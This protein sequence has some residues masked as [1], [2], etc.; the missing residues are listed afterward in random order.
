M[1]SRRSQPIHFLDAVMDGMELPKP[2]NPM[3]HPMPDILTEISEKDCL[4]KLQKVGLTCNCRLK[5]CIDQEV[6]KYQ[7]GSKN[8]DQSYVGQESVDQEMD[9]VSAPA[10][11]KDFL[12]L[13]EREY[14]L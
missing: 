12:F 14:P 9:D 11:A 7:Q 1:S 8:N 5:F 3:R 4:Q 10:F 13:T 6:Q 2:G